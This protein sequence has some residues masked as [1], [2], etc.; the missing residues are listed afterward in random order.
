VARHIGKPLTPANSF[1]MAAFPS[2]TGIAAYGPTFPKPKTALPSVT[3]ATVFDFIVY[4]NAI[5]GIFSMALTTLPTPGVYSLARSSVV[6]ILRF[7]TTSNL[8]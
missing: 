3:I 8:P 5:S 4:V 6:L 7:D 2:I 1:N